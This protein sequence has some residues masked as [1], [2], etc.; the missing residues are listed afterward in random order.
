MMR[1]LIEFMLV[2]WR[3]DNP[4]EAE[5]KETSYIKERNKKKIENLISM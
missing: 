2:N 1:F 4:T 5:N 3:N